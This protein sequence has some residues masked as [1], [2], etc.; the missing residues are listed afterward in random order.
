MAAKGQTRWEQ[1]ACREW[2]APLVHRGP[3]AARPS[4]GLLE[5]VKVSPRT[6]HGARVADLASALIR[7]CRAGACLKGEGAG[8]AA[9]AAPP[10]NEQPGVQGCPC[11]FFWMLKQEVGKNLGWKQRVDSRLIFQIQAINMVSFGG[12]LDPEFWLDSPKTLEPFLDSVS[13]SWLWF[14]V[15]GECKRG[16][17]PRVWFGLLLSWK[18]IPCLWHSSCGHVAGD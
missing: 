9:V 14:W 16:V 6:A 3:H 7:M 1:P 5:V 13:V 18:L 12:C 8:N 4:N 11:L 10:Q 2:R 17:N 15:G